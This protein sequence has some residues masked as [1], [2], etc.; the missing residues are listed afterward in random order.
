MGNYT[1]AGKVADFPEGT[2]KK[3]VFDQ[4]EIMLA[5]VDGKFYAVAGRCPHMNGD[6]SLGKL[7]GAVITCPRHSSQFNITDG[8]VVRWL[9]GSGLLSAIG[10]T[11]KSPRPLKTYPIKIEGDTVLIEV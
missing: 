10:K 1:E 11:L 7:E 8:K 3:V 2:P 4:Q 9:K 6:L 5:K